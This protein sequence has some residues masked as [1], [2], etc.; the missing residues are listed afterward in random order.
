MFAKYFLLSQTRSI[1]GLHLWGNL[2]AIVGDCLIVVSQP[3]LVCFHFHL[4]VAALIVIM[5][6]SFSTLLGRQFGWI[7]VRKAEIISTTFEKPIWFLACNWVPKHTV[8]LLP[9]KCL[10]MAEDCL[11]RSPNF[12]MRE[13]YVESWRELS[14][15]KSITRLHTSSFGESGPS[16][17]SAMQPNTTCFLIFAASV[18]WNGSNFL[19]SGAGPNSD[20]LGEQST[21]EILND[22]LSPIVQVSTVTDCEDGILCCSSLR[23]FSLIVHLFRF[24]HIVSYVSSAYLPSCILIHPASASQFVNNQELSSEMKGGGS[25]IRFSRTFCPSYCMFLYVLVAY[26]SFQWPTKWSHTSWPCDHFGRHVHLRSSL[27][28]PSFFLTVVCLLAKGEWVPFG[29]NQVLALN[30]KL[31]SMERVK[32]G[33][34]TAL[35]DEV[36]SVS[37][38]VWSLP[39]SLSWFGFL[40]SWNYAGWV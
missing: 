6:L 39:S 11:S 17:N 29:E 25:N 10:R 40:A 15:L 16:G 18:V 32:G 35:T 30:E 3:V 26:H 24:V 27:C 37:F 28:T 20:R 36:Y 38:C 21:A 5:L 9:T 33:L 22:G 1:D 13:S 19:L 4:C 8:P 14:I 2:T 23:P 12:K 34:F 31:G 7:S